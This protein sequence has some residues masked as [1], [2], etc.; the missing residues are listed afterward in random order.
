MFQLKFSV[1]H[2]SFLASGKSKQS[3]EFLQ[4]IRRERGANRICDF[5]S[6]SARERPYAVSERGCIV[7]LV[8]VASR[9]ENVSRFWALFCGLIDH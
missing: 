8:M 6:F 5:V 1:L 7:K 9:D 4:K 3:L 2:Y